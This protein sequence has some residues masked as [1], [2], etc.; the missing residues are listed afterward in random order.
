MKRFLLSLIIALCAHST[1]ATPVT[2][3]PGL[4]LEYS[5][6]T[7]LIHFVMPYYQEV[8][9]TLTVTTD[10]PLPLNQLVHTPGE[11]YFSKIQFE[12]PDEFDY[13]SEAGRPELPFYSLNL[14]LPLDCTDYEVVDEHIISYE[15][16]GLGYDYLPSQA[17]NYYFGDFTYDDNYYG[18][19]NN[20]WYWDNYA[21][22]SLQYRFVN[23]FV[24]SLFPFHY[25]PSSRELTVVTEATFEISVNGSF[26]NNAYLS[27]LL[28]D[29]RSL[30][31]YFDNFVGFPQ[32][33][34]QFSDEYLI[35]TADQWIYET[36]LLDFVS[37]KESLGYHVT[38][39]PLTDIGG[40]SSD[41]IRDY[42]KGQFISEHTKYVLLIGDVADMS[43]SIGQEADKNDP[44]SDL[45]Y[46]CLSKN[47][48]SNQKRDL[49]P[50][51]FIGRW[52]VQTSQQLRHIVDKT[53]ASDLYLG[54][55]SP[56]EID[57]FAGNGHHKDYNYHSCKHI[58]DH[59]VQGYSYYTGDLIDGRE[60]NNIEAKSALRSNL[61]ESTDPT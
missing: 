6:G 50:S 36:A 40:D 54:E 32:P 59:V 26:L 27:A 46:S 38:L 34:P 60:M 39:T 16:I 15:T 48:I 57:I 5:N 45:Y 24:F 53:I 42:I 21:M 23:G 20:T 35:I 2:I 51:V 7:Y 31:Y 52:P 49:S 4:T 25:E 1:F 3:K 58:Y 44:P 13:L 56:S 43:F 28:S 41:G 10:T 55:Y 17:D 11:Y 29:D 12:G 37:H 9:D 33:Y 8:L 22:D 61:E 14:L 19:Y 30:Y 47:N 18:Y